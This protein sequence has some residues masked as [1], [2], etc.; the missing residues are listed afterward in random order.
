MHHFQ[1]SNQDDVEQLNGDEE[2]SAHMSQNYQQFSQSQA[3]DEINLDDFDENQHPDPDAELEEHL[4]Q[5][6]EEEAEI[7]H[8]QELPTVCKAFVDSANHHSLGLMN[9]EFQHCCA[10]HFDGEKL[11]DS[12]WNNQKF[13]VCCLQG[14]IKLNLLP[15]PP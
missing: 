10:L 13:G 7:S 8:Q 4:R 9:I 11:S 1:A 15:E 6:E 14:Q 2:N 3:Q 5:I 12:T